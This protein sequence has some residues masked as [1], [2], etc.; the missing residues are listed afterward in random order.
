MG[1]SICKWARCRVEWMLH[2]RLQ[3]DAL[4]VQVEFDK[5]HSLRGRDPSLGFR[6]QGFRI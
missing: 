3:V 1:A 6:I 2:A 4:V 5:M